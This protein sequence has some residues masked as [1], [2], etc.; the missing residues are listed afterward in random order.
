MQGW[1]AIRAYQIV[2]RLGAGGMGEVYRALDTRL[3][4]DVAIKISQERF[5][6]RFEREA[7]TISSLNHPH[8]CTLYIV[9]LSGYGS[10]GETRELAQTRPCWNPALKLQDRCWRRFEQPINLVLSIVI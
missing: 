3:G 2:S 6:S 4:R 8:I 7:R 5:S 9:L 1:P 10:D